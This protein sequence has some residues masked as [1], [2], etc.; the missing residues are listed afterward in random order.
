MRDHPRRIWH[1]MLRAALALLGALLVI[2]LLVTTAFKLGLNAATAGFVL[3]AGVL[4]IG[5]RMPLFVATSAAVVSTFAYNFFFFPPKHT[6]SIEDPENWIALGAFLL[7]SLVANRLVA[8]ERRQAERAEAGRDQ[9]EALY[10]MGIALLR[11][12]GGM[13][14]IG[15]AA[16]LYLQRIGAENGGLILFGASPQQQQVLAWT[17]PPVTDEIEDLAA[18]AGRHR[19]FID[20]PSAWGRDV[21]IPLIV[22][23][24]ATAALV[25][26]G[27]SGMQP[28]LESAA[29]LLT[30][31]IEHERFVIDRAHVEALRQAGEL[32][33]SLI[34][35]VSHDLKSPL[36]VLMME[37]EAL[38]SV[39]EPGGQVARD[40]AEVIRHEV[41]R[42][43][44]RLDNLLSVARVKAG[45][46]R[47]RVE[48][49]PP[50]DLFRAARESLPTVS[51]THAISTVVHEDA[52]DLLVDPSLAL[53]IVVNLIENAAG[54]SN[55]SAPIELQARKSS[56]RAGRLWIEVMD[57]GRGM[58]ADQSRSLRTVDR[59]DGAGRIGMDLSRTLAALSDGT[60]EWFQREG[61]G[62][63]ARFDA[64]AAPPT[65]LEGA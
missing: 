49:T 53:E 46:V 64:P 5:A 12:T 27:R 7:T 57:R 62:T 52:G 24:R 58:D 26:R 18:G 56:E 33:S 32:Q 15:E 9:I 1:R 63:I 29:S 22:A 4:L 28:A 19:T 16:C 21:C 41:S 35:A 59:T 30:F 42:L 39:V 11:K 17:G 43:Q 2:A 44:R 65:S 40:H 50:A 48:P 45:A 47:P 8:R 61:G 36:T 34:Q 6:L 51:R 37:S 25:V 54:A 3:L 23:G 31:A 60:V 38:E 14:E 20:I 10:E 55:P 13:E